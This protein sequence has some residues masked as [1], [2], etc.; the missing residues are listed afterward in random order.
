M[1][2]LA[3]FDLD[4]TLIAADSSEL[5]T[6]YLWD[7]GIIT[8]SA[9]L[10]NDAQIMSDYHAGKLD[11]AAY[12]ASALEAIS[13]ATTD[14]IDLWATHFVND[15]IPALVYPA[16]RQQLDSYQ[17]QQVPIVIL[18]ATS[19]FI[20]RA[21]GHYLGIEQAFGI[22]LAVENKHYTGQ[23]SGITTFREGKV[24]KLT[25]WMQQQQLSP[26]HIDFYTDS[27]NDLP[28][29]HFATEVFTVNADLRLAQA[30]Q[31]HGWHTLHWTLP[32]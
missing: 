13:H 7:K 26:Q 5:W 6:Q 15:T 1:S 30:A 29:C 28:L 14:E 3:V 21:V 25:Q 20:V 22:E 9:F 10:D 4:H 27:A 31:R 12:M 16:A 18:S 8:D 11:M 17:R 32:R 2:Q 19:D 24:E 23:L